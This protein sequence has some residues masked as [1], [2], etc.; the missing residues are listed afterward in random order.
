MYEKPFFIIDFDSTF[1]EIE[2]L[3][4]L[5]EIILRKDTQKEKKLADITRITRLGMEGK[6]SFPQSLTKRLELFQINKK[7]IAVLLLFLKKH[8]TPS[9]KRNK[10]F[11]RTHKNNIYIISG[12][13]KEYIYP[14]V[15][16]FGIEEDH[17]LANEFVFDGNDMVSGFNQMNLLSLENGKVK[18][19]KALRLIGTVYVIGDGYTDYQ[20]KEAG[21]AAKFY[22]F[23]ENISRS[24]VNKKADAVVKNFDEFL[25]LLH[26]PRALSYPKTKI[27]ILLLENIH[28]IAVDRL[29]REGYDVEVVKKALTQEELIETIQDVS[30]LGIRSKTEI[31]SAVLLRAKKLLSIGAF[32]IG[33]NQ[34]DLKAC[35]DKGVVVFNAPFSNTRSVAEMI[36]GEIIML[37]RNI[38]DK[39]MLLHN[40]IW[41]KSSSGCHEIRGRKLG[42][43][44]YG[45]IGSQ[46]SVLAESLGMEVYFYNTSDR[47]AFGNAKKCNSMEDLLK[48]ADVITVHVSGKPANKNLISE[49][50]FR[51]MKEGVLFLNASRGFVVDLE[52][53]AK[54]IYSGKV[55]GAAIDVYPKE[56]EKNGDSFITPLQGLPNVILTPHLGS[57][58][59][60]GQRNIGEFVSD[61]LIKYINNGNTTLSVNFPNLQLPLLENAHRFIH[62]HKNVPGI[63][64]KIN[65]VL[66]KHGTN[67]EGQYLQTNQEIGYVITDVFK[68]YDEEVINSLKEIPE[69]IR[70]RLLY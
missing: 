55:A 25:Y 51:L 8:I 46:V 3:D 47:L 5:A 44:G 24:V 15:K 49:K 53:L 65:G 66:S 35:A 9:I 61:K 33:T 12:G 48:I 56:P 11:F 63:L 36:L 30:V 16:Q 26:M 29:R 20:I 43:I 6:L 41:D 42:I 17:V 60:E 57:G 62:V 69:T 21:E 68:T 22:A 27:K 1:I 45:H 40:G 64:A 58:T 4:K 34:I 14:I 32:C 2:A 31:N 37:S 10:E 13:F 18:Q 54:A 19:V 38:S 39:N 7:H 70:F 28:E 67:I 50:E 52:Q 23:T 59:D